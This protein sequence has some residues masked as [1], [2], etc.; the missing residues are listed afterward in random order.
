MAKRAEGVA[1][2]FP[3]GGYRFRL[4]ENRRDLVLLEMLT[5]R[6]D[7][8]LCMTEGMLLQLLADAAAISAKMRMRAR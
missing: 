8:P 5:P 7:I 3:I 6:G 1:D 2:P 4:S